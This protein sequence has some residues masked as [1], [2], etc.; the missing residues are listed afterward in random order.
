MQKYDLVVIGSGSGGSAAAK[1]AAR[2]GARVALVEKSKQSI[3][4][5]S[6]LGGSITSKALIASAGWHGATW[7]SVKKHVED[8]VKHVQTDR[9]NA[10]TYSEFGIDLYYGEATVLANTCVKAGK[11]KLQAKRI[12]VASGSKAKVPS[13][14]GLKTA[15]YET[16]ESILK[17]KVLPPTLCIIGGGPVAIEAA[18]A[19]AKLGTRVTV[20]EHNSRILKKADPDAVALVAAWLN[21]HRAR[22]ITSASILSLSKKAASYTLKLRHGG[23]A[24]N[25][26]S[27]ILMVAAGSVPNTPKGLKKAGVLKSGEGIKVN[28][29]WQTDN[30]RIYAIGDAIDGSWHSTHAAAAAGQQAVAHAL[31]GRRATADANSQPCTIFTEPQLAQVGMS[32]ETLEYEGVAYRSY[33][34]PFGDIDKTLID[35]QAG[36][37]KLITSPHGRILGG[38]IAGAGACEVIGFISSA[39]ARRR[40]LSY[41]VHSTPPYP[42]LAYGLRN[43]ALDA[44]LDLLESR[45]MPISLIRKLRTLL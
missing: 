33:I 22:V 34:M 20:I 8:T 24:V 5:D 21:D 39:I 42:S 9:E 44:Q 40:T 36:F 17:L 41:I 3:G 25:V 26:R 29:N 28:R 1:Y 12:I 10:A 30:K 4:G 43:L 38:V 14:R 23:K 31:F 18:C 37:I 32:S 6:M 45:K 27:K 35:K 11:T 7:K 19:F 15:G 13:I 2:L 16:H